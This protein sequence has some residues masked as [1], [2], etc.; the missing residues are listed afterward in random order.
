M[1][2][3]KKFM[4]GRYGRDQLSTFLFVISI[5]LLM[6]GNFFDISFLLFISYVPLIIAIYRMF[7]KDVKKR[8]ME[9]Y[10][11]AIFISP[12]YTKYKKVRNRIKLSKTLKYFKCHKCNAIL[13]V[14]RGKGKI[15][16]TCP[17]CKTNIAKKT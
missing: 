15:L 8:S 13:R 10:K 3:L 11:F 7:S 2:S 4:Q 14:P 1:N 5:A 12:I 16:V 17:K 6:I 9:N